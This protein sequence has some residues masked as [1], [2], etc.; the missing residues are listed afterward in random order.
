MSFSKDAF[1]DGFIAETQEHIDAINNNIIRLK[2]IPQSKETLSE[3]LRELH[4]IKGSSRMLGFTTI[5]KLSHGIEDVF[6]GV[7]EGKYT[8]NDSIFQ[9][10]L[11]TSE[12]ILS[13]L[14]KIKSSKS[15]ESDISPFTE[16][17]KKAYEGIYFSVEELK[18]KKEAGRNEGDEED[19]DKDLENITSIRIDISRINDL[20]RSFDNLIIRQFRFKHQLKE[21]ENKLFSSA[22]ED[23]RELP[24]QL[25]EDL[26]LTQDAIFAIQHKLLDLRM[27][28][29]N[30][31]LNPLKREVAADMAQLGKE[32]D[33]EIENTDLML[34]KAILEKLKDILMHLIRNS[35]DHG[36]E[37][38]EE[39]VKSG[40]SEK[41]KI[42]LVCQ[43]VSN[44]IVISVN[45][46]GRG[47][48]YEK[49]RAKAVKLYPSQAAE[50]KAM[51]EK[52]LQQFLFTSGF[53]TAEKT[54]ALS[55]RGVGLDVVRTDME[56][57]KGRIRLYSK[58]GKGTTFEL[59]IPLSLATQQ[60]LFIH[61]GGNKFM[62]P[63]QYIQQIIDVDERHFTVMQSQTFVSLN[64][65]L[66][67]VYYLSSIL[68]TQQEADASSLIVLE[69]LETQL[70]IIVDSIDQYENVVVTPLPPIL[71]KM[72]AL[73]G[74]VY[75]ENYSII[76]ILN[77][78]DTISRLRG[79]LAYDMKKYRVKNEKKIRTVLVVDD[80]TTTR[81]IEQAIFETDGYNVETA[82]DGIDALDFL[83]TKHADV[84][85]TDMKM[86][87]MDGL[88]LLSNIRR[89]EE[90]AKTPV[91]IVS[92][93]YD[94]EVKKEFMDAGAQAFIVK[95]EFQRG[96][97][98]QAVKELLGE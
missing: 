31:V 38:P 85:I 68:G 14:K 95:S 57:I 18:E 22:D 52:A 61:T 70:A 8:F 88:V 49:V 29:L 71:K 17:F 23:F 80:S 28:P 65:Q 76:P 30:M 37:S 69:Y 9:L 2:K 67:P 39:R 58:S 82:N 15:D 73:Q 42:S 13:L 78:P 98:L 1:I 44:R 94:P 59:T 51:S 66:I 91:I 74:V 79:L 77:I 64:Q 25:K 92:G 53:T 12:K 5:E 27:L 90:Y 10:T 86:P 24:K 33:F 6:K 4:T 48:Q 87:R 84:I 40:K 50:I 89:M 16:V 62:I 75:D 54:T 72:S 81:Q 55:G 3:I 32:I 41:G 36:I 83:R 19:T 56:K 21:F 47:I 11:I 63:S 7:R 20:L 26:E 43:Q 45:D 93:V 60:G 97:L 46:D 96:N 35:I 34:D